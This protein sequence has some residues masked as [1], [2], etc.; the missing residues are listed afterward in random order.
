MNEHRLKLGAENN[1]EFVDVCLPHYI[2]LVVLK[3][4]QKTLN[5]RQKCITWH[6]IGLFTYMDIESKELE[7][8]FNFVIVLFDLM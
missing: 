5:N 6:I 1:G 4:Q 3:R 7:E 2:P 8:N